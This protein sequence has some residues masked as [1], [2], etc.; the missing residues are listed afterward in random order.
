MSRYQCQPVTW[1]DWAQCD[2][3]TAGFEEQKP[4]EI[5][6]GGSDRAGAA[7]LPATSQMECPDEHRRPALFRGHEPAVLPPWGHRLNRCAMPKCWQNIRSASQFQ[8]VCG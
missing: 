8:D 5:Q 7:N 2:R 1:P 3:K 6:A 4:P